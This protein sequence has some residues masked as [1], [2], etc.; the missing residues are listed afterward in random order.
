MEALREVQSL[1][2]EHAGVIPE[3]VYLSLCNALKK[4]YDAKRELTEFYEYAM[5]TMYKNLAE[6]QSKIDASARE[7][8]RDPS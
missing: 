6:L 2:D 5:T 8:I 3:G 7:T 4:S 1:L